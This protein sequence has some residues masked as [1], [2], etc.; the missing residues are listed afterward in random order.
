MAEA[1]NYKNIQAADPTLTVVKVGQGIL[2][3][4][5]V[6]TPAADG[7][8]KIYDGVEF[9]EGIDGVD[10]KLIGTIGTPAVYL[11]YAMDFNAAFER[12]LI[13][14]TSGAA[15]DITINYS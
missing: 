12:G 6:N 13:I 8:I 3:T 11:A 15:Q 9:A 7:K 5:C 2:H 1:Y 14:V 4:V 10:G